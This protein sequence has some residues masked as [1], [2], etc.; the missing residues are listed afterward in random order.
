VNGRI[1]FLLEEPSMKLL[2]ECLLPRVFPGW[3]LHDHFLCVAHEGKND[4][5]KS[6]P[7]KLRAWQQRGDRFVVV[8]DQD[9][10]DCVALKQILVGLC[11]DAG[12]PDSLVRIVCRE[13]EAWYIGDLDA[14]SREYGEASLRHKDSRRRF[15]SPDSIDKP[16]HILEKLLPEFQK[17][18]G[19]RRMGMKISLDSNQSKSFATFVAGVQ[20]VASEMGYSVPQH[21]A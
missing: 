8:H 20:R 15:R 5:R 11:T 9:N 7:R 13:L 16:S 2:L 3:A 14:L 19:A 10:S 18:S 21:P 12:R 4:L 1:V 17:L 6:I